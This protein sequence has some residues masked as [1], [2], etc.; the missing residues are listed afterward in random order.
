[1][2]LSLVGL[3]N[4]GKTSLV[5]AIATGGYSEDMIPTVGFNMR[6][7]WNYGGSFSGRGFCQRDLYVYRRIWVL[8]T[9]L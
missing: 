1:M 6:K 7:E 3:Q 5:N 8:S 4:T 2:E 9:L